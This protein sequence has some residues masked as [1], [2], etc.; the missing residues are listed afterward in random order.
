MDTLFTKF[1]DLANSVN[2][3][4]E[5]FNM[6]GVATRNELLERI[7]IQAEEVN[8]LEQAILTENPI[9]IANEAVAKETTFSIAQ[10]FKNPYNVAP[11]NESPAPTLSTC[12]KLY[13][14]L[15]YI[16]LFNNIYCNNE[17]S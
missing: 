15:L 7:P 16:L 9:D 3:L 5:R 1:T 14:S 11:V 12:S 8:E 4:H 13:M 6:D 10:L 17:C 2:S